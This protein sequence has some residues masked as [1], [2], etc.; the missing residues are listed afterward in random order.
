VS[1]RAIDLIARPPRSDGDDDPAATH[2]LDEAERLL[3]PAGDHAEVVAHDRRTLR[4]G[5][6]ERIVSCA[7]AT[8]RPPRS[9]GCV[10]AV[11][12]G[13]MR[14]PSDDV[15]HPLHDPGDSGAAAEIERSRVCTTAIM[16]READARRRLRLTGGQLRSAA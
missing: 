11:W 6:G 7:S 2:Y 3:R 14:S 12:P 5:L 15:L 9:I 4:A 10:S 1:G 16:T 8:S 13:G